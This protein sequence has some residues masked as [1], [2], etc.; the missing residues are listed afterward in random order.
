MNCMRYVSSAEA[1]AGCHC[2][3]PRWDQVPVVGLRQPQ[4]PAQ[5]R[6]GRR[7]RG[8]GAQ[9]TNEG[10]AAGHVT[11]ILLSDWLRFEDIRDID[12]PQHW[13]DILATKVGGGG[14]KIQSF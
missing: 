5:A 2:H 1:V 8:E 7:A 12:D 3:V 6:H 14:A 11:S 4:P 13:A 9:V 10:A